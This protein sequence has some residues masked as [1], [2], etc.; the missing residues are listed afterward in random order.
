VGAALTGPRPGAMTAAG[1]GPP[2]H[3][4]G[5]SAEWPRTHGA[6][7]CG[8]GVFRS[9]LLPAALLAA[10][11]VVLLAGC[12]PA[13]VGPRAAPAPTT[14]PPPAALVPLPERPFEVR[15]DDVDPCSLLAS[16]EVAGLGLEP[17]GN[18]DVRNSALW[19]GVTSL[20]SWQ[21]FEPRSISVGVN[22]SVTA[23]VELFTERAVPGIVTPLDVRGFPAVLAR[24]DQF[25]EACLVVVDVADGQA[26]DVQFRA[27]GRQPPVPQEDLCVG[28]Q[29]VAELV[30]GNLLAR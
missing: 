16:E 4:C 3:V 21:G 19:G 30:M 1:T 22:L 15:V 11:V 10:L 25:P 28:A 20:C 26:L 7:G 8:H 12:A 2:R 9:T 24:Q 27:G 14:T 5:R 13:P 29:Q 17:G 18:L 23:G 6:C